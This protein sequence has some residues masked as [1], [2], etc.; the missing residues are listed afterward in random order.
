MCL[1]STHV[2]VSLILLLVNVD[3]DCKKSEAVQQKAK[4]S[5]CEA[6]HTVSSIELKLLTI[7]GKLALV[8]AA[9]AAELVGL[10]ADQ[11]WHQ[12]LKQPFVLPSGCATL[13]LQSFFS[14][15]VPDALHAT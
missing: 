6:Q 7:A 12:Q 15:T 10:W 1:E 4:P 11:G 8:A 5:L 9:V 14:H 2:P 3:C 13:P